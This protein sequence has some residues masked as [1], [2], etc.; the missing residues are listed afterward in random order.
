MK[1]LI[2]NRINYKLDK[3]T[4]CVLY[5]YN[6]K[7]VQRMLDFDKISGKNSP[8]IVGIIDPRESKNRKDSIFWG[9]NSLLLDIYNNLEDCVASKTF[10][11]VIN[12]MSFRSASS[13]TLELLNIDTIKNI[14][15][16]AEGVT[17]RDSRIIGKIAREKGKMILGPA[18]VGGIVGGEFRIANTGGSLENIIDCG[19][20]RGDGEISFVTRS[21][22]LLNELSNIVSKVNGVRIGMSIGGDRCPASTFV[23]HV[24]SLEEDEKTKVIIILGEVGG[25]QELLVAQ[26]K[27]FG[28]ITKPVIGWCMGISA[29]KFGENIQ[30]GHAGSSANSGMEKASFKNRFMKEC[31]I[32]VPK[33]FDELT[34][35]IEK[36][37]KDVGLN[38]LEKM[39]CEKIREIR[40]DR[41]LPLFYS[42]I[43]NELGEE[44][45]YNN[46]KISDLL[47]YGIGKTIGHLWLKKDIPEWFSKFIELVLI[48]V[49]DHGALVSGAH[50]TIVAGRAGKDLVSSLCSGLLTIGDYF[51][52]ALNKSAMQFMEGVEMGLS[53]E[54][55]VEII[56][57]RGQVIYGIGH[58]L[59]TKEN[60]DMRVDILKKYVVENFPKLNHIEFALKVEEVTLRK[61]NNLILNVDGFIANAMLDGLT[62]ILG[63]KEVIEIVNNEFIN[64]F[65]ILGRTIGF[66]GHWHDQKRLG[67][68]LFRV[69]ENDVQYL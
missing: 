69:P 48:V 8:S 65:F 2:K 27:K 63:K 56:K 17:E 1:N 52:G 55:F 15:I 9:N 50:N 68:G 66:I 61:K 58:K 22:G 14:I 4:N 21:G 67:Q 39:E 12:F 35:I 30:F 62:E 59:K 19:L 10:D 43:S 3:D 42:S 41:K 20:N 38:R 11:T 54:E 34:E 45:K 49:A 44:L 40:E 31:G 25:I 57:K 36:V 64:A 47:G 53:P 29:E 51:G 28:L 60:P 46:V 32:L 13:T 18:T 33:S 5:G 16:I 23:D 24:L 26:A 6:K 37:S 7:A